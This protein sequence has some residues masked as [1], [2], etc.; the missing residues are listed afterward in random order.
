MRDIRV[1]AHHAQYETKDRVVVSV[2]DEESSQF[3]RCKKAVRD[4]LSANLYHR[5][6]S[7][8]NVLNVLKIE[9]KAISAQ[10][11]RSAGTVTDGKGACVYV[12]E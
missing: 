4:N 2:L 9:H 10:L 8:V 6:Y 3:K 1:F 5:G 11:Q 7:D 12:Y